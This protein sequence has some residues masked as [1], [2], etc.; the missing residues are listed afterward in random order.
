MLHK[1]IITEFQEATKVKKKKSPSVLSGL[2]GL[3]V[4]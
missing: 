1:L 2:E 4:G 3:H